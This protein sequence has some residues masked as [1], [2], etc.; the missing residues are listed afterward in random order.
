MLVSCHGSLHALHLQRKLRG[1]VG[2]TPLWDSPELCE[3]DLPA[4]Q[5]ARWTLDAM[6]RVPQM[7][8]ALESYQR[9]VDLYD[10]YQ[11]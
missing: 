4:T 3:T 11:I 1:H 6:Q 7:L 10:L 2:L 5:C 9:L 8:A